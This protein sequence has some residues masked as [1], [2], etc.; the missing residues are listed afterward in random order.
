MPTPELSIVIP[1]LN[2][3]FALP[4]LLEDLA[5]QQGVAFEVIVT[6]GGSSDATC[7]CAHALFASGGLMGACHVGPS[8][9]GRQMNAGASLANSEWLLFLHADSRLG[10]TH[11]LRNHRKQGLFGRIIGTNITT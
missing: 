3:A 8:G 11:Q 1:T 6:D 5:R 2:E 7:Q 4:L 9:R 10:D